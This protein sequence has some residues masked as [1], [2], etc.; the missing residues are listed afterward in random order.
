MRTVPATGLT[1]HPST[2]RLEK[3][4]RE[5]DRLVAKV[6]RAKRDHARFSERAEEAAGV[7]RSNV[8]PLLER[9]R[10]V[11]LEIRRLFAEILAKP[12][13]SPGARKKVKGVLRQ[14]EEEMELG[15]ETE[16]PA[17]ARPSGT[18]EVA[19]ASAR[20]AEQGQSS[21]RAVFKRVALALHPD[22]ASH[23]AERARRTEL[24]KEVTSAYD[25]GDIAKLIDLEKTWTEP[26]P[27][28]ARG[29]EDEH[30]R[31]CREIESVNRALRAQVAAIT[32]ELRALRR[33]RLGTLA[34]PIDAVVATAERDLAR[35][36]ATRDL[37]RSFRDGTISLRQFMLGPPPEAGRDA[38]R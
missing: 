16:A 24:M 17:R 21:L 33:Q 12:R 26:A 34:V 5:R 30:A 10:A 18:A 27:S 4:I 28:E 15:E 22:R 20:G 8:L 29:S 25:E 14:L 7:V 37:V 23:D 11:S 32:R 36:V 31:R 19:S 2:L 13:L 3:L 1:R 35:L 38:H 9:H 6:A